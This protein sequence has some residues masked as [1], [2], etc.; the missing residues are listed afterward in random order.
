MQVSKTNLKLR[1]LIMY[2]KIVHTEFLEIKIMK[3][4]SPPLF[5]QENKT[6]LFAWGK[7]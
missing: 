7:L 3:N 5:I 4:I 2:Q 6:K 1:S